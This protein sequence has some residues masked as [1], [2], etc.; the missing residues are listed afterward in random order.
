MR[1]KS[2]KLVLANNWLPSCLMY[3]DRHFAKKLYR[4]MYKTVKTQTNLPVKICHLK[5]INIIA[6]T[7]SYYYEL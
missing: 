6:Q 1:V 3:P 7:D 4:K 5:V 2:Q